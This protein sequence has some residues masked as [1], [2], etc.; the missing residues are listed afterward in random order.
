[1]F[2]STTGINIMHCRL[3]CGLG[4]RQSLLLH[5]QSIHLYITSEMKT[6]AEPFAVPF[7]GWPVEIAKK[8]R[9]KLGR[10]N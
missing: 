5:Q 10:N 1:M 2:W 3:L 8:A 9:G 7:A 6:S 4:L